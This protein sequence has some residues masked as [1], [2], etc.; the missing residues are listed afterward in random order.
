[1][2]ISKQINSFDNFDDPDFI[3]DF[4]FS[5]RFRQKIAHSFA[6]F[7]EPLPKTTLDPLLIQHKSSFRN[8]N[9]CKFFM[10]TENDYL[11]TLPSVSKTFDLA[12]MMPLRIFK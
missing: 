3:C 6:C 9:P 12:L 2:V 1:M 7:S 5:N 8:K 4:G 10:V 11:M